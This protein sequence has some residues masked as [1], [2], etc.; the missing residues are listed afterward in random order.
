MVQKGTWCSAEWRRAEVRRIV[1]KVDQFD[2]KPNKF[3]S[4]WAKQDNS[5]P[6]QSYRERK[7]ED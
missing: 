6:F 5:G 4:L 7:R 1:S 2:R 3:L